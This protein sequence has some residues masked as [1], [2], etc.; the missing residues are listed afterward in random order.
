VVLDLEVVLVRD[1]HL[2]FLDACVH[3]LLDPAACEAHE[4]VVMRPFIDFEHRRHA[5]E[6]VPG[7]E[8]GRLEL[9]EHAIDGGEAD[10]LVRFEQVLVDV[11]G[12]HVPGLCAAQDL[13]DLD[14]RQRDLEPGLAQ[15][16]AF[17]D[18]IPQELRT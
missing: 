15:I 11:L 2:L 10:V 9:R 3:E 7:H 17:Q 6:V 5:V 12:A 14:P 18:V 13:E 4:V 8:A 1:G 16:V